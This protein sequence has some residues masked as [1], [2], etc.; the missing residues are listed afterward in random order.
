MK[1]PKGSGFKGVDLHGPT[2]SLTIRIGVQARQLLE[3]IAVEEGMTLG[4]VVRGAITDYL[5]E[6][7]DGANFAPE[8]RTEYGDG[9]SGA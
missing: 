1:R 5:E 8:R 2:T 6:V 4:S 9:V 3:R 7:S